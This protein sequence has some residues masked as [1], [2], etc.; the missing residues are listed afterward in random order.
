MKKPALVRIRAALLLACGLT[1]GWSPGA[2][3]QDAN[4]PEPEEMATVIVTGTRLESATAA[5]TLKV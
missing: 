3:A 5:D 1:P 2:Q 4:A